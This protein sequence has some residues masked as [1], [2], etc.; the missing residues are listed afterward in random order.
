MC[1]SVET[2]IRSL[3]GLQLALEMRQRAAQVRDVVELQ[4]HLY[5]K[6][7]FSVRAVLERLNQPGLAWR[8][9]SGAALCMNTPPEE[10][11][12][13]GADLFDEV[14]QLVR[15][16]GP[17]SGLLDHLARK[18]GGRPLHAATAAA[19]FILGIPLERV[20]QVQEIFT[21]QG[22]DS[23][24]PKRLPPD[25]AVI[26]QV[27]DV[28]AAM[29]QPVARI[30]FDESGV[31]VNAASPLHNLAAL[32]SRTL[33]PTLQNEVR[34]VVAFDMLVL[35]QAPL[36]KP[37]SLPEKEAMAALDTYARGQDKRQVLQT[38][39]ATGL[40]MAVEEGYNLQRVRIDCRWVKHSPDD[41]K[42]PQIAPCVD[43]P[44]FL[45]ERW[46]HRE[47]VEACEAHLRNEPYP[48]K[49]QRDMELHEVLGWDLIDQLDRC[50]S[51]EQLALARDQCAKL[52]NN[53]TPRYRD[54]LEVLYHGATG[55]QAATE[56]GITD[57]RVRVMR[58]D[59]RAD[60]QKND[61]SQKI[62]RT[63]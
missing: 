38:L 42:V 57:T 18:L 33:S 36:R 45:F 58:L 4:R 43:L 3:A 63:L 21:E 14:H 61:I 8:A 25:P 60:L 56:L 22:V 37:F 50:S 23:P 54:L 15:R 44:A 47:A 2:T 53:S 41:K 29:M 11:L 12:R 51:P 48:R 10:L 16:P 1:S 30:S 35:A 5:P 40:A 32:V 20:R 17:P 9:L 52:Y 31:G 59:L 13:T 55:P 24:R 62:D 26:A 28:A 46:L 49:P 34:E 27:L 7:L 19:T 6:D 39:L